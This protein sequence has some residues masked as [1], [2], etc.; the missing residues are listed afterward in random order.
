[1]ARMHDQ[2]IVIHTDGSREIG[3]GH[4]YR[5]L[6]LAEALRA[7]GFTIIFAVTVTPPALVALIERHGHAVSVLH[8][9]VL[10]EQLEALARQHHTRAI[11]VD[12]YAADDFFFNSLAARGLCVF[13]IH[14]FAD[15]AI[16]AE[17]VINHNLYAPELRYTVSPRT[18]LLL[19]P[20]YA[21]LRAQFHAARINEST[22]A[23]PPNVLVLLGGSDPRNLT[24]QI[25]RALLQT[26]PK[27]V[28]LHAVVGPATNGEAALRQL[29]QTHTCLRVHQQ[30]PNLP[31]LMST[32]TLAISGAGVTVYELACLG[33]P[34]LL[35]VIADNQRRNAE[36]FARHRFAEV[37]GWHEHV[38]PESAAAAAFALLHD[39]RKLS[40]MKTAGQ[41]LVD[42]LGTQRVAEEIS[43]ALASHQ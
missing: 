33:V 25:T 42:G 18:R 29:A 34:G 5:C 27:E 13:C 10:L 22:Q 11:C 26:L 35:L 20:R 40:N 17:L 43:N 21:L 7:R 37:L 14:D 1:M 30:P 28:F 36:A 16:A 4:I 39:S 8:T 23:K 19:G 41:S 32:A 12:T 31:E 38:S 2:I 9:A 6:A 24:L 15:F 3:V